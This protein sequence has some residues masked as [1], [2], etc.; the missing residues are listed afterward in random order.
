MRRPTEP[1]MSENCFSGNTSLSELW[2]TWS[3]HNSHLP[4]TC[5]TLFDYPP[6]GPATFAKT[7]KR[8]DLWENC[9]EF[10][11]LHSKWTRTRYP[12]TIRK[13]EVKKS[14]VL[15]W[16]RHSLA[17][18]FSVCVYRHMCEGKCHTHPFW[19]LSSLLLSFVFPTP[20]GTEHLS[21]LESTSHCRAQVVCG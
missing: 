19:L 17:S 2:K 12:A 10:G 1:L 18:M 13:S 4:N 3:C 9:E 21:E 14:T 7:L 20:P 8:Q 6:L 15:Y 16:E 5:L 11:L